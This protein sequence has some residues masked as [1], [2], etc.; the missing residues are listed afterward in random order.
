MK[1]S[2]LKLSLTISNTFETARRCTLAFN[3]KKIT[4]ETPNYILTTKGGALNGIIKQNLKDSNYS[5]VSLN[6]H[7]M[8]EYS[9]TLSKFKEYIKAN[10]S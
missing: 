3:N 1:A 4:L 6:M 5:Q 10:Y 9:E 8:L 7:D 2:N